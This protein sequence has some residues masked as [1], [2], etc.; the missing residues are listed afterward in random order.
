MNSTGFCGIQSDQSLYCVGG[1]IDA[2]PSGSYTTV[3]LGFVHQIQYGCAINTSNEVKCWSNN[4]LYE[5]SSNLYTDAF[6]MPYGSVM[7]TI[8]GKVIK[9]SYGVSQEYLQSF[10]RLIRPSLNQ[11]VYAISTSGRVSTF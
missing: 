3:R 7:L 1:N 11:N 6:P 8:D 5:D 2:P 10:E 4:Y 9:Y